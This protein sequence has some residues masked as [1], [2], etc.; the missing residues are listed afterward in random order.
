[1]NVVPGWLVDLREE[2]GDHQDGTRV[3]GG[4]TGV[5]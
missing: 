1:M 2:E 3:E 4:H 5:E